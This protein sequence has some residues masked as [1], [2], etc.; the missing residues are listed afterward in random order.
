MFIDRLSE[1]NR[2]KNRQRRISEEFEL[3][4]RSQQSRGEIPTHEQIQARW[5]ELE[6]RWT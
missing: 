5:A 4:F 3:E 2:L 6:K 1:T